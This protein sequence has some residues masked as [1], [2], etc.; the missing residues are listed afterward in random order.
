MQ[1]VVTDSFT[2]SLKKMI[3]RERWYWKV[4]DLVRYDIPRFFRNVWRFRKELWKMYPWDSVYSLM[5]LKRNLEITCEYIDKYGHEVDSSRLKKVAAMKR[6]IDILDLHI[7]DSFIELAEKQLGFNYQF[8]DLAFDPV[9]GTEFFELRQSAEADEKN[10]E[11]IDLAQSLEEETW[12][13]LFMLLKGQDY[14]SR[15]KAD[16]SSPKIEWDDWF[17]GSGI[18]TWWD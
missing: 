11:I 14:G 9:E 18:K 4:W 12:E 1:V 7:N 16:E 13:E 3:E 2:K 17:D 5:M 10:S 15:R 8:E 6:A